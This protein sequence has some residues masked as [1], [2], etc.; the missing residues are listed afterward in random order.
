D[1]D[2]VPNANWLVEAGFGHVVFVRVHDHHVPRD[3]AVR[4]YFHAFVTHD[5]GIA[6]QVGPFADRE[7]RARPDFETD[8]VPERA[9]ARLQTPPAVNDFWLWPTA[10][11]KHV[12]P[13][14]V[15]AEQEAAQN[16]THPVGANEAAGTLQRRRSKAHRAGGQR[17]KLHEANSAAG[18]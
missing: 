10:D 18:R 6:V 13:F 16:L 2:A 5:N 14:E 1:P 9:S 17:V 15:P 11:P 7:Q 4:S 8:P 3:E 12:P